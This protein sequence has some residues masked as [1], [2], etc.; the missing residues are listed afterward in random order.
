[1]TDQQQQPESSENVPG[2]ARAQRLVF[3]PMIDIYE[4]EEGL[5]L[6]ADLPGVSADDLELQ[7]QDNKLT[8]FGRVNDYVPAGAVPVHQEYQVGDYLRSFIL[9]DEVDYDRISASINEGVLKVELPRIP[10]AKPRKIQIKTG[11]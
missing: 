6:I 3:T 11:Q 7:I 4:S 1:M 10:R 5:T 2:Y 9:S 8:L